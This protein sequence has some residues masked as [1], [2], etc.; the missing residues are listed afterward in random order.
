[1]RRHHKA[2]KVILKEGQKVLIVCKKRRRH[3]CERHFW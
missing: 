3:C 2:I 1:M